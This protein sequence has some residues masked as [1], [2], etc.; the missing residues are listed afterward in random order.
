MTLGSDHKPSVKVFPDTYKV[1]TQ[2]PL[3]FGKRMNFEQPPP[4]VPRPVG[5]RTGN[6]SNK[7]GGNIAIEH[8]MGRKSRGTRIIVSDVDPK[9]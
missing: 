6:S 2:E 7:S 9:L 4:A 1:T 3:K 8:E 5:I